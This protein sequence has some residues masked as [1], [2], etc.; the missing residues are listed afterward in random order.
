M[1]VGYNEIRETP[2]GPQMRVK[3]NGE[4]E[5][6]DCQMERMNQFQPWIERPG[7]IMR[8]LLNSDEMLLETLG[9]ECQIVATVARVEVW[10]RP[11]PNWR[12]EQ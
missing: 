11:A 3:V 6:R 4:Y 2:L 12:D 8:P 1:S 10:R 5:W 7:Y 9:A